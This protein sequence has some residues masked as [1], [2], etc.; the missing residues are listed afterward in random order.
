MTCPHI[1]TN[2]HSTQLVSSAN[3]TQAVHASSFQVMIF[4]SGLFFFLLLLFACFREKFQKQYN[5]IHL[6]HVLFITNRLTAF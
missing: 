2:T 4:S 5:F 1:S 6:L 3:Y